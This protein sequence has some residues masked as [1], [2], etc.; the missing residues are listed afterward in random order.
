MKQECKQ[1]IHSPQAWAAFFVSFLTP[2]GYSLFVWIGYLMIDEFWE[3]RESALHLS[4]GGIYFGGFMLLLPFCASLAHSTSQVDDMRTEM[5][6]WQ[7]IRGGLF[8][9][10]RS[11][12]ATSM[13]VAAMATAS[14]F[15]V[16]A[17]LWNCIALP[18]D[19]AVYPQHE[20]YFSEGCIFA[21]CYTIC[22]GLPMY[23]EVALGIAFTAGIW[24]LVGLAIAVW[25]PDKLLTV[26]IPSFIY[27]LWSAD[28]PRYLIGISPPHPA[29]LFNDG[30][31]VKKAV[32][33]LI[34]YLGIGV[35]SL[36]IYGAGCR[37]RC[38]N[39]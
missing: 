38:Q 28:A 32:M 12:A 22:H 27:Y 33:T 23:I 20:M 13:S 1:A 24:A 17:I 39:A 29:S 15:V 10:M 5:M 9:Y 3:W 6:R 2:M 34:V 16:H 14:A 18:N 21:G 7:V 8:K 4:L 25:I 36:L 19:P 37:K 30:L 31:T 26:T 11:K 35:I